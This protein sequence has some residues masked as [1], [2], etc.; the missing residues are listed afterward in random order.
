VWFG[1]FQ[2][3]EEAR[4]FLDICLLVSQFLEYRA[5]FSGRETENHIFIKKKK[6]KKKKTSVKD[7]KRPLST[8]PTTPE[9]KTPGKKKKRKREKKRRLK[10]EK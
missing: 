10:K 5:H 6:K 9:K 4:R 1:C 2:R 3:K 7:P 8:H